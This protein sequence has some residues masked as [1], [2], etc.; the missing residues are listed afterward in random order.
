VRLLLLPGLNDG[1]EALARTAAWLRGVDPGMRV[2]VT[3]FRR[4][5]V[6]PAA[7]GLP[8]PSAEQMAGYA[9]VLR[10]A[11]IREIVVV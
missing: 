11:G 7:R 2:Q 5:G 1:A 8:E 3:G 10:G 9:E 6:R 4:H